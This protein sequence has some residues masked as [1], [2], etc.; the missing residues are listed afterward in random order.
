MGRDNGELNYGEGLLRTLNVA[1]FML[2]VAALSSAI[3]CGR[4]GR[5][6]VAGRVTRNDGSPLVGARITFRNPTTGK[7]AMGFTDHDGRYQLGTEKAGEGVLPGEYEVT[8]FEDRGPDTRLRPRT[9]HPGYEATQTSTLKFT[10]VPGEA[11]TYD[12]VLKPP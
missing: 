2:F 4:S 7:S 8:V 12:I 9:I 10:V 6:E 1:L 11:V 3:G 5:T